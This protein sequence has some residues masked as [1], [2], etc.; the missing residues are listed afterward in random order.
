M[1]KVAENGYMQYLRSRPNASADSN[2]RIKNLPFSTCWV[3]SIFHDENS[4]L[5]NEK[6]LFLNNMRNYRP[7]GVS[8]KS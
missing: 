4:S 3:H 6:E 1:K 8:I 2:R 7:H 5:E